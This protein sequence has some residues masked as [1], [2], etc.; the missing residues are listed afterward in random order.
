MWLLITKDLELTSAD[1]KFDTNSRRKARDLLKGLKDKKFLLIL[2]FVSDVLHHLSYWSLRMQERAAVLVDFANFDEKIT[3]TFQNLKTVNGR[4]LTLFLE[5][6]VCGNANPQKCKSIE[7]YESQ[8]HVTYLEV[9]LIM[10]M[11]NGV[12]HLSEI[13]GS[14][15]DSIVEDIRSY[16]PSSNLNLFHIFHPKNLTTE[17]AASLTYGIKEINELCQIFGM[18]EC[19]KLI[20][21]WADLLE[22]II[23]SENFCKMKNEKTETFAFWSTFLNEN[24]IRWTDRTTRLIQI[25]LVLPIGSADAERGFSVMNHIKSQRRSKIT[26]EHMEA[27]MRIR[28][29]AVDELERYPGSKYA[30]NWIKQNHFRTDDPRRKQI[31]P[32]S[33]LSEDEAKKKYLPKLSFL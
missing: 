27:M 19:N 3:E 26:N 8:E 22:S 31:K 11:N 28:I 21:D 20:R 33:L 10:D 4:D 1:V 6:S 7:N 16:F 23:L 9:E 13:R 2:N 25:I 30:K 24:G 17:E 12:P 18:G 32:S 5:E 14:F 29:N 15:F